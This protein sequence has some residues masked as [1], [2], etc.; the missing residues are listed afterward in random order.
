M[1]RLHMSARL[2]AVFPNLSM[3]HEQHSLHGEG[4][5][6][7]LGQR[8]AASGVGADLSTLAMLGNVQ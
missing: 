4:K 2:S 7:R 1:Q 5:Q 3:A 8:R 6:K